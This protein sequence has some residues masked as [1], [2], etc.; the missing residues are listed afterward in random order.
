MLGLRR[1]C[2]CVCVCVR[3]R[4]AVRSLPPREKIEGACSFPPPRK[5]REG[6]SQEA[7]LLVHVVCDKEN[8]T[9]TCSFPLWRLFKL[10]SESC[11]FPPTVDKRREAT[12]RV[13][14]H[15]VDWC[16]VCQENTANHAAPHRVILPS[17]PSFFTQQQQRR[18]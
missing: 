10:C 11:S 15:W 1:S 17:C 9:P 8:H 14:S 16:L 13:V 7:C 6:Q 18:P 2:A 5:P 12:R 4:R 3:I